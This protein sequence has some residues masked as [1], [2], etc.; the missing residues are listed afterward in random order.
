MKIAVRVGSQ[1]EIPP[2]KK[3]KNKK[4]KKKKKKIGSYKRTISR[5][6]RR[7]NINVLPGCLQLKAVYGEWDNVLSFLWLIKQLRES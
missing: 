1:K 3:K 6:Y 4:K 7:V 2:Q 5:H